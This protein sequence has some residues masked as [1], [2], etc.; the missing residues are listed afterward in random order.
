M[1][2]F[3]NSDDFWHKKSFFFRLSFSNFT[4]KHRLRRPVP[5]KKDLHKNMAGYNN[6]DFI[7]ALISFFRSNLDKYNF[8]CQLTNQKKRVSAANENRLMLVKIDFQISYS[9]FVLSNL[10]PTLLFKNPR[11]FDVK[12]SQN[13]LATV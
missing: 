4:W 7:F 11:C 3:L 8:F 2:S 1:V 13:S 6:L 12:P 10:E 5:P 9:I